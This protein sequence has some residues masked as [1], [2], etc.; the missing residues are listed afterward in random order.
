[1][2]CFC[3]FYL[4]RKLDFFGGGGGLGVVWW[5]LSSS[6]PPS[7]LPAQKRYL[8]WWTICM[9]GVGCVRDPAVKH[10]WRVRL[11]ALELKT[12]V[13]CFKWMGSS[14][15]RSGGRGFRS[16]PTTVYTNGQNAICGWRSGFFFWRDLNIGHTV[17]LPFAFLLV[18]LYIGPWFIQSSHVFSSHPMNGGGCPSFVSYYWFIS[19]CYYYFCCRLLLF[20]TPC[21]GC[22]NF[23]ECKKKK[24]AG[25]LKPPP[26][27]NTGRRGPDSK[28]PSRCFY[29]VGLN[30]HP[31]CFPSVPRVSIS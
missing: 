23:G 7:P 3:F 12:Q 9:C 11:K 24:E 17:T 15:G 1:M 22:N 21:C 20:Y 26:V 31:F 28:R 29:F 6:P 8:A 18:L 5:V 2:F 30:S 19:C 10:E 25:L 16:P 27:W 4:D 13:S 14:E